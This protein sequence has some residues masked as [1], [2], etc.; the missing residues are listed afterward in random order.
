MKK[1]LLVVPIVL[2]SFILVVTPALAIVPQGVYYD[3]GAGENENALVIKWTG[4][5]DTVVKGGEFW[6]AKKETTIADVEARITEK[7]HDLLKED[8]LWNKLDPE[9]EPA[10]SGILSPGEEIFYD[11]QQKLRVWK[12]WFAIHIYSLDDL[13]TPDSE[14]R[15]VTRITKRSVYPGGT[16]WDEIFPDGWWPE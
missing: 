4:H 8:I 13:E 15:F 2:L 14:L 1:Y 11:P 3:F 6:L 10:Y 16:T 7:V 5:P 9:E 12:S